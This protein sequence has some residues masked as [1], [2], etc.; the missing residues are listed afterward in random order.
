MRKQTQCLYHCAPQDAH[1][2]E[3]P[4][5]ENANVAFVGVMDGHASKFAAEAASN[6]MPKILHQQLL[7]HSDSH[8]T[9]LTLACHHH[10]IFIHICT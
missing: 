1:V 2:V 7:Q 9:D 6:L 3:F 4:L 5:F 8:L 10:M